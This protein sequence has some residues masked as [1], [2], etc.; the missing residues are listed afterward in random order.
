[1]DI[2]NL[3]D[4]GFVPRLDVEVARTA[5]YLIGFQCE[6]GVFCSVLQV[7][8]RGIGIHPCHVLDIPLEVG[9]VVGK[10]PD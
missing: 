8:V 7:L 1:M 3:D 4:V 5:E 6:A 9:P 10:A 2:L